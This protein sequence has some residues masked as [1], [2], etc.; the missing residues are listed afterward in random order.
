MAERELEPVAANLMAEIWMEAKFREG[1]R[2][3]TRAA[4]QGY[5]ATGWIVDRVAPQRERTTYILS[6]GKANYGTILSFDT[7]TEADHPSFAKRV[8]KLRKEE[9]LKQREVAEMLNYTPTVISQWETGAQV[10]NTPTLI[11][12]A[13]LFDCSIDY[14]LGR[15]DEK[16]RR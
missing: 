7:D 12:V 10:P 6:H 2:V 8:A 1:D 15:S 3:K 9:G 14:L 5:P 13:D 16:S 11:T 4:P